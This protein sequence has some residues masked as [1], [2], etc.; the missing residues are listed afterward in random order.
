[1]SPEIQN[2]GISSST[3]RT[4]VLQ[5]L[6]KNLCGPASLLNLSGILMMMSMALNISM[7]VC[8]TRGAAI[9]WY[10]TCIPWIYSLI[11]SIKWKRHLSLVILL[12]ICLCSWIMQEV[13][14]HKKELHKRTFRHNEVNLFSSKFDDLHM[15]PQNWTHYIWTWSCQGLFFYKPLLFAFWHLTYFWHMADYLTTSTLHRTIGLNHLNPT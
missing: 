12:W 1:M 9:S 11:T 14:L 6:K 3:K 10:V 8:S 13:D 5:K 2:R 15:S 4:Y 7:N